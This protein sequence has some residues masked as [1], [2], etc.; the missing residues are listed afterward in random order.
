MLME[1]A[2]RKKENRQN[3]GGNKPKGHKSA[4]RLFSLALCAGCGRLATDGVAL[5]R[6][7]AKRALL[8]R[9]RQGLGPRGLHTGARA[10][11]ARAPVYRLSAL[12][13]SAGSL[14]LRDRNSTLLPALNPKIHCVW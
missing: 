5:A 10:L 4:Q 14:R 1:Q 12:N 8:A 11:R 2:K 9:Q 7:L 3:K 13:P 6:S